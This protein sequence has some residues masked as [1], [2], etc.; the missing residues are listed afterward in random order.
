M[1]SRIA[2]LTLAASLVAGPVSANCY[3]TP[4]T[5]YDDNAQFMNAVVS[6]V[7]AFENGNVRIDRANTDTDL[8][9]AMDGMDSDLSC[10]SDAMA[11]FEQSHNESFRNVAKGLRGAAN[12]LSQ[13]NS[14]AHKSIVAELNG[15]YAREKPG[16]KAARMAASQTQYR[17]AWELLPSTATLSILAIE[18]FDSPTTSKAARMGITV[19]QRAEINRRVQVSFPSVVKDPGSANS[20]SRLAAAIIYEALNHRGFQM[21]DQPYK[22]RSP[23][24]AN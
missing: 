15:D 4:V 21:H 16:D 17:E 24:Q 5:S 7:I 18:E 12:Q 8:L 9:S 22:E 13:L 14:Q 6:S 23:A 19:A 20:Q 11:G 3:N 10:A 2:G 1:R